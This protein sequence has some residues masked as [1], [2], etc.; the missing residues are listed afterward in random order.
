MI[1]HGISTGGLFAVVGMIYERYHTRKMADLGGL[2]RRTP[3]LAT[4]A[5]VL[6]FSSIGLPGLNGFVG[7]LLIL[8]GMFQR[9]WA[10]SPPEWAWQFRDRR[11]GGSG[12]V[13]GAWYML[14]MVQR[15]FFGPVAQPHSVLSGEAKPQAAVR[16]LSV[17]EVAALAPLVVLV[18]W[19][20]LFPGTLLDRMGPTLDRLTQ[21]AIERVEKRESRGAVGA[22]PQA[23]ESSF[24][25][26]QSSFIISNS[27]SKC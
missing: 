25:I 6:A 16:D 2:A 4:M 21:P 5:V 22:K 14:G 27:I 18:F 23:A 17:R 11:A 1:N 20:G 10:D 12:V 8:L 24:I 15:V 7:E 9:A 3:L 13:L 26:H 19:I